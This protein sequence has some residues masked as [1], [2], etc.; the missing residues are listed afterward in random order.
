MQLRWQEEERGRLHLKFSLR[1]RGGDCGQT[2]RGDHKPR[3]SS[4]VCVSG[5]SFPRGCRGTAEQ[6]EPCQLDKETCGFSHSAPWSY[7]QLLTAEAAVLTYSV[8]H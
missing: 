7:Q 6:Q 1:T 5:R 2:G 3:P 4:I 8:A